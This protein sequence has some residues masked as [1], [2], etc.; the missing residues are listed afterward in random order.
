M[1]SEKIPKIFSLL[2]ERQQRLYMAMEAED[3]GHGGV[4]IVSQ[5]S[6]IS[7]KTIIKG[8][9]IIRSLRIMQN[10]RKVKM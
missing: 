2:N 7:R 9:R 3:I 8:K 6:G 1:L 10:Y 5:A 4:L